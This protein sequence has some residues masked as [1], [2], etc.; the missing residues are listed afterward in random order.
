MPDVEIFSG[1]EDSHAHAAHG[2][3]VTHVH[4]ARVHHLHRIAAAVVVEGHHHV[5]HLLIDA[6]HRAEF[7]HLR[8]A[9][10][11]LLFG[12]FHHHVD[13]VTSHCHTGDET[14][15]HL[16]SARFAESFAEIV[17]EHLAVFH[18][19]AGHSADGEAHHAD[20]ALRARHGHRADGHALHQR[21]RDLV[22]AFV[23][24]LAHV[25]VFRI[26]TDGHLAFH[27]RHH[28]GEFHHH[29]VHA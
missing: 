20:V 3:V 2:H 25:R 24:H 28:V 16:H 13:G 10:H 18:G 27:G 6:H 8:H 29:H 19:H 5:A 11:H 15:D 17:H 26:A 21:A 23:H 7:L 14:A 4:A 22:D 9:V 1:V 12:H